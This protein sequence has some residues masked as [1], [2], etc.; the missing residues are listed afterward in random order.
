MRETGELC[1]RLSCIT[2]ASRAAA[3]Q[4]SVLGR[5]QGR[6]AWGSEPTAH[7]RGGA[8]Q[9]RA[10]GT[11]R[12]CRKARDSVQLVQ[13]QKGWHW[14]CEDADDTDAARTHA[15]TRAHT[16]QPHLPARDGEDVGPEDLAI[17][18]R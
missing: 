12:R 17:A 13:A 14:P 6:A 3:T 4:S 18:R 1:R 7:G 5:R 16:A 11:V 9:P 15:R 2:T 8:L 10:L